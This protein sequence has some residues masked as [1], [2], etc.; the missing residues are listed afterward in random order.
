MLNKKRD[1]YLIIILTLT[2]AVQMLSL[3]GDFFKYFYL[4]IM[5]LTC[6]GFM[7][8]ALEFKSR[9]LLPTFFLLSF[10]PSVF[11]AK[12]S[13]SWA[14]DQFVSL[15]FRIF[16]AS[17]AYFVKST[18]YYI[19]GISKFLIIMFG[20]FY[21]FWFLGFFENTFADVNFENN[22]AALILMC[23]PFILISKS[24]FVSLFSYF[25]ITLIIFS[26][27]KMGGLISLIQITFIILYTKINFSPKSGLI[28]FYSILLAVMLLVFLINFSIFFPQSMA[29]ATGHE[30]GA[31]RTIQNYI[32]LVLLYND[33]FI[34][35]GMGQLQ[36]LVGD[37]FYK[38]SMAHGMINYIW[39]QS[40]LIPFL[41]FLY[42]SFISISRPI[43]IFFEHR[44]PFLLALAVCNA[45]N[46]LF[47]I[48]RPQQGNGPYFIYMFLGISCIYWATKTAPARSAYATLTGRK[49]SRK[50]Y[51]D[52][53]PPLWNR[54]L[55]VSE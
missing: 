11:V 6:L 31:G 23:T 54:S 55:K 8:F 22:G 48:T 16:P 28:T 46:F 51:G 36:F 41:F 29:E 30:K 2:F 52:N 5:A 27:S 18:P 43:R 20:I 9:S 49:K 14:V 1:I 7:V 12:I 40:G 24:F 32:G 25:I 3:M 37:F 44:D 50:P 47:F 10:L 26:D 53:V 19:I 45:S 15:S 17:M 21:I 34:G 39:V 42:V 35:I 13:P 4:L 38:D 33:P